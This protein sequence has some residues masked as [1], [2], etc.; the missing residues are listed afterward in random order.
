MFNLFKRG[1][2]NE[3]KENGAYLMIQAGSVATGWVGHVY[4]I[5]WTLD[6]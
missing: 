6:G 4:E 1:T 2:A 5:K 3:N